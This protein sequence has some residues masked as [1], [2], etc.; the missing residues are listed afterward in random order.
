MNTSARF[1]SLVGSFA[2]A[3][4]ACLG[5]SGFANAQS[6][7]VVAELTRT[8][9]ITTKDGPRT[10]IVVGG[11]Q[12]PRPV[13]MAL[14]GGGGSAEQ[15][16]RTSGFTQAA[17]VQGMAVVYPD[18]IGGHWN[19]GR[20]TSTADDVDFLTRLAAELV[21]QRIAAPGRI[22]V[23]GVSNGGMMTLRLAC[24]ATTRFTGF[25]PI[26]ASMPAQTG[27]ACRPSQPAPLLVINGT[28]D[29]LVPYEGGSVGFFGKRGEVWSTQ[30][31][32]NLFARLNA[33]S[34]SQ[35][36]SIPDRDSSD[37]STVMRMSWTGCAAPTVLYRIDGGGHQ[38]PG[39][40]LR[41]NGL[42]GP[43]NQDISGAAVVTEFLARLR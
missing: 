11:N 9:T 12:A 27:A 3:T 35:A 28:A 7:A 39:T 21:K 36:N 20:E 13:L 25:A 24:E 2:L 34:G 26:I 41:R 18:G 4:T 32:M 1:T 14:H 40:P 19:D 42:T 38:I 22:G 23:T 33:C 5:L 10:A 43:A 8:I 16:M 15:L 17:M 31:T 37:G 6:A 29:P 30:Q